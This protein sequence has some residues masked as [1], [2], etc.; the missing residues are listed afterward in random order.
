MPLPD[1]LGKP[2]DKLPPEE[3]FDN[4][5]DNA[6][7]GDG[8]CTIDKDGNVSNSELRD[9]LMEGVDDTEWRK[10]VLQYAIDSGVSKDLLHLLE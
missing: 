7:K 3:P 8:L 1:S 5:G 2:I 4:R 10:H 6:P 9:Q